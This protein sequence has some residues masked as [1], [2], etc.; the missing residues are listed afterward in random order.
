M[1]KQQ[2][3]GLGPDVWVLVLQALDLQSILRVR[4]ASKV[5]SDFTQ[6]PRAYAR[7]D[8][9]V[10]GQAQ[11]LAWSAP[12]APTSIFPLQH[13]RKLHLVLTDRNEEARS[14][15]L[16]W[17][18]QA[19]PHLTSLHMS[20]VDGLDVQAS[21]LRHALKPF[22]LLKHFWLVAALDSRAL[23]D[24]HFPLPPNCLELLE[25]CDIR[26]GI[27][28][29]EWFDED[30]IRDM[31]DVWV[32]K[33]AR[34]APRLAS[35]QLLLNDIRPHHL[36]AAQAFSSAY[37]SSSLT[38]LDPEIDCHE[39]ELVQTLLHRQ[40]RLTHLDLHF[41]NRPRHD[42][43]DGDDDATIVDPHPQTLIWL[44]NARL[45][46]L[47]NLQ[48]N[49]HLWTFDECQAFTALPCMAQLT[50]LSMGTLEWP[51]ETWPIDTWARCLGPLVPR[52]QDLSLMISITRAYAM[53]QHL[54]TFP[55]L[56][57]LR[58]AAKTRYYF[59]P[60]TTNHLQ[61]CLVRQPQLC[62]LRLD[63]FEACR[64]EF[65]L[66]AAA[67][68]H[69]CAG[70]LRHV[71]LENDEMLIHA[72]RLGVPALALTSVRIKMF[73]DWEKVLQTGALPNVLESIEIDKESGCYLTPHRLA[74][75]A[76]ACP[77]LRKLDLVFCHRLAPRRVWPILASFSSL[78]YLHLP[79]RFAYDA[80]GMQA[81]RAARTQHVSIVFV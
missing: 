30:D 12:S 62:R 50:S 74:R 61:A 52:L 57:S 80:Q 53:L 49:A 4:C 66:Q 16:G 37:A 7:L 10:P 3:K 15:L 21:E 20:I 73:R 40:K 55:A 70:T 63:G 46:E 81:F 71:T 58:L 68:I 69:A 77:R 22:G 17:I 11:V 48:T 43:D 14:R 31:L 51:V 41:Y 25:T 13:L 36:V 72:A 34:T 8:A 42:G 65:R 38:Y 75:L 1:S 28:P 23:G 56:T 24:N 59:D 39:G 79:R 2:D 64:G 32:C 33:L 44:N 35:Y 6:L 29:T 76:H 47:V 54:P 18:G 60:S 9:F 19:M 67:A 45:P 27:N 5:L 26:A 78:A